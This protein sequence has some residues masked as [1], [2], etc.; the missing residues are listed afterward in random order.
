M[1]YRDRIARMLTP[2]VTPPAI[3][4]PSPNIEDRRE[5]QSL[6]PRV[7]APEDFTFE[8]RFPSYAVPLQPTPL[9]RDLGVD[10]L[11]PRRRK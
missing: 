1:N 8:D 10:E 6:A 7:K 2:A 3:V 5:D 4:Q 11:D 9:G